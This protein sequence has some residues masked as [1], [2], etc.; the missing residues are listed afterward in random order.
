MLYAPDS[1]PIF[2]APKIIY[3]PF[4]PVTKTAEQ[5]SWEEIQDSKRTPFELMSL[6]RCPQ[7]EFEK[8]EPNFTFVSSNT[9]GSHKTCTECS[10]KLCDT[11]TI[12]PLSLPGISKKIP[13]YL[14]YPLCKG[15]E[16]YLVTLILFYIT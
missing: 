4:D 7:E 5:I 2:D 16:W 13:G 10:V 15:C 11:N 3:K 14:R 1:Q 8:V 9:E 12:M 6:V